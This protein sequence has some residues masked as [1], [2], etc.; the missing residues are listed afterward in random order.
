[1]TY[2]N[3]PTISVRIASFQAGIK[4]SYPEYSPEGY[5]VDGPISYTNDKV[6]IKFRAKT[7]SS[8]FVINQTKSSWDSSAVKI[9]ADK[10][11]NNQTSESQE[12]GLTIYTY[13][14]NTAAIWVNGGILYTI[15]GNAKLTGEQIR[16]IATSL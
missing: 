7:G 13:S 2:I 15:S 3:F 5:S 14:D 6:T 1:M 8:K 9:Q 16:H 10:E 12:G 4:A 11:S